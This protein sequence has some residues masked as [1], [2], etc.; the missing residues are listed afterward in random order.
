MFHACKLSPERKSDAVG[1]ILSFWPEWEQ[2][3]RDSE[4]RVVFRKSVAII[5][6]P[7]VLYAYLNRPVQKIIGRAPLETIARHQLDECLAMSKKSGYDIEDIRDYVGTR[8]II[9]YSLG[10]FQA[11]PKPVAVNDLRAAY[12]FVP[13]PQAI[14]LS[15]EGLA[16]LDMRLGFKKPC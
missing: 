15:D 3:L 2:K 5:N 6:T 16:E 14:L 12:G 4:I 1:L 9:V 10:R 7:A 8:S 13:T 11:A